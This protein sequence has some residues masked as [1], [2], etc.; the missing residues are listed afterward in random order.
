MQGETDLRV[1]CER[2]VDR[3]VPDANATAILLQL[4]DRAAAAEDEG[5]RDQD[6]APEPSEEPIPGDDT[7]ARALAFLKGKQKEI[8]EGSKPS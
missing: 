2:L 8:A 1:I 4:K 7:V 6:I 5:S 3:A